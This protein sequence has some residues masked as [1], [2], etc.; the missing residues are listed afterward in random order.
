MVLKE[1]RKYPNAILMGDFNCSHNTPE[2]QALLKEST[3]S[4]AIAQ[5]KLDPDPQQRI[6]WIITRG[7]TLLA[8]RYIP[9]GVSDHPYYQVTLKLAEA[10]PK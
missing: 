4:D 1:F 5:L 7:F 3:A 10:R 9:K 6:D 8:G 2:I